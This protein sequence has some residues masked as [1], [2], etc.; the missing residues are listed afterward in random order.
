V[1]YNSHNRKW[2]S[3]SARRNC[4]HATDITCDIRGGILTVTSYLINK[5]TKK[6]NLQSNKKKSVYA[7]L[8]KMLAHSGEN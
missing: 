2:I 7:L 6:R 3:S 4:E 8:I 5:V 1:V